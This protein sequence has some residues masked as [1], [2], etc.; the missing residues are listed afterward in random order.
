MR[1][2]PMTGVLLSGFYIVPLFY[3]PERWIVYSAKLAHPK[4]V[5]PSAF[6]PILGGEKTCERRF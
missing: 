3:A 1:S 2:E 6:Q 5:A 4:R